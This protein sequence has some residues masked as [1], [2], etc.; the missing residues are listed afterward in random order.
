M[1][2]EWGKA[3]PRGRAP[4]D[5]YESSLG[6]GQSLSEMR[7]GRDRGGEPV[8]QPADLVPRGEHRPFQVDQEAGNRAPVLNGTPVDEFCFGDGEANPQ[9][10][11]S[12]LQHCLLPL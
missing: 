7:G 9:A 5:G 11:P 10:G 6:F 3:H 2:Q 12:G 1:A 4:L 8:P